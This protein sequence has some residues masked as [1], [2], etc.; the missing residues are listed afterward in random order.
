MYTNYKRILVTNTYASIS[1][2]LFP[3][4][5][6]ISYL[7]DP[8]DIYMEHANVPKKIADD[9][10]GLKDNPDCKLPDDYSTIK[11]VYYVKKAY[12]SNKHFNYH[13][14][15]KYYNPIQ[16][17]FEN[18]LKTVTNNGETHIQYQNLLLEA[19]QATV[20]MEKLGVVRNFKK[21]PDL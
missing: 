6:G 17:G 3:T 7:T 20:P 11:P 21:V 18:A 9:N 19:I 12:Y 16:Q 5:L 13:V 1:L 8:I 10:G 14:R 4:N 2:D 15:M